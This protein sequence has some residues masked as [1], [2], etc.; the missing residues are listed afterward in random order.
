MFRIEE[1]N[2]TKE[3]IEVFDS[4]LRKGSK[5]FKANLG[6]Q[7]DHLNDIEVYWHDD[8]K[9]WYFK[10]VLPELKKYWCA[11][12][13][14][15]PTSRKSL[16]IIC[17]LNVSIDGLNRSIAGALAKDEADD[18]YCLHSGKIGG[19]RKGIGKEAFLNFS[20]ASRVAVLDSQNVHTE[21]IC[22]GAV[23]HKNFV[24]Q[25]GNFV[26]E[27]AKFKSLASSDA[28]P[29]DDNNFRFKPEFGGTKVY[30]IGKTT[31]NAKSE[32]GR[33]VNMLKTVV[34]KNIQNQKL[35]VCNDVHVDL[36]TVDSSNKHRHIFEVK[37]DLETQS[38]YTSI[39]QLFVHSA[40]LP[41]NTKK[42]L[43]TPGK[44]E[45]TTKF[46]LKKLGI[47]HIS[48]VPVGNSYRFEGIAE[49]LC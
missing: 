15:H 38:I 13:I 3:A 5:A 43:V 8:Q 22:V 6:W 4:A 21:Y 11:F 40:L 28:L 20:T 47:T 44:P 39:G 34:E 14:E 49:A 45:V 36:F 23:G 48:V 2:K 9:F 1:K 41:V 46:L 7:G 19:G 24:A 42:I 37:T 18:L 29:Q 33:I 16:N 31:I 32:H 10:R 26:H 27:V 30:S 17:E 35:R 25:V 12:G